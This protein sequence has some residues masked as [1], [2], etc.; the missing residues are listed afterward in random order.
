MSK[1]VQSSLHF[2]QTFLWMGQL[3]IPL[4]FG[5]LSGKTGKIYTKVFICII[6]AMAGLKLLLCPVYIMSDFES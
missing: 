4:I 3:V 2:A 1:L 5:A 6:D